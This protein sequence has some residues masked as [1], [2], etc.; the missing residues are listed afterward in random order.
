MNLW[1]LSLE[2]FEFFNR[3]EESKYLQTSSTNLTPS[4]RTL[5]HRRNKL[6]NNFV[7]EVLP[8]VGPFVATAA[9][10]SISSKRRRSLVVLSH[11]VDDGEVSAFVK[12][13]GRNPGAVVADCA[14]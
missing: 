1:I 8:A 2:I 9:R 6:R 7:A 4:K 12:S 14:V 10:I 11:F 5:R 3:L 13:A